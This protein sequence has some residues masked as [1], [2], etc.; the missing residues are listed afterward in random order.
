LYPVKS[1]QGFSVSEAV[2]TRRG[3]Q[4]DRRFMVVD[5]MG[6]FRTIRDHPA[7]ATVKTAINGEFLTISNVFGDAVAVPLAP[8]PG[9]PMQVRVWSSTV[10]AHRVS[11]EADELLSD[12]LG[13]TL[14]LVYMPDSTER[15][16][17][18]GRGETGDIVSF[19]DGYPLLLAS[20]SSLADLNR[21]IEANGREPVP[22]DRFRAN[23]VVD[24]ASA[25]AEDQ[26]GPMSIGNVAFR[27]A[28]PCIRCQVTT[29]DQ[30]SGE[31]CGPEPLATLSTFRR[32]PDGPMFG[33]NCI[34]DGAGAIRLG[35][36]VIWR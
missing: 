36:A 22:M 31:L 20:M 26:L 4:N 29:T 12:V 13:E 25:F 9:T 35:D 34:P 15:T 5:S 30:T 23:V 33:A 8:S 19:A 3:L 10:T 6:E 18:G 14:H 7:M 1:L 16:V 24:G 11:A 28:K 21:R 17:R 27:S 2:V 32:T